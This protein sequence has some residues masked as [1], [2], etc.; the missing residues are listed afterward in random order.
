[1]N[2]KKN[3]VLQVTGKLHKVKLAISKSRAFLKGKNINQCFMISSILN[4]PHEQKYSFFIYPK[5]RAYSDV[6]IETFVQLVKS[7]KNLGVKTYPDY[8]LE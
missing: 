6:E 2:F 4:S 5:Q 3:L 1:M 8:T 7:L